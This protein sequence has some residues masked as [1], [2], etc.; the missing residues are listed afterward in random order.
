MHLQDQVSEHYLEN[1][2]L[3]DP[4]S[5]QLFF[6]IVKGCQIGFIDILNVSY[7]FFRCIAGLTCQHHMA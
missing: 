4:G 6:I 1:V 2:A 5:R 7:S 3:S